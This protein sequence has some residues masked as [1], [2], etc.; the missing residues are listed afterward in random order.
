MFHNNFIGFI[1]ILLSTSFCYGFIVLWNRKLKFLKIDLGISKNP[2]KWIRV[3]GLI[4]TLLFLFYLDFI[5]DY[6]FK[7]LNWRMDFMYHME[8]GGSPE[9]YVDGTDSWAKSILGE[10]SSHTLYQLKYLVSGVFI[11]IYAF[12]THLAMRWVYPKFNTLPYTILLYGLGLLMMGLVF[13][14]YFFTWPHD[15]K[16]NF[17]LISM[18]I[19]HFLESSLPTLLSI[20]GFKIYLSTQETKSN[21]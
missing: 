15:T 16:L 7:N 13:S 21:E 17:Y 2:N 4:L 10:T 11:L 9:K 20:L 14:F 6:V 19:G 8:Q 12:V 5:R 1:V 3:F 18:E